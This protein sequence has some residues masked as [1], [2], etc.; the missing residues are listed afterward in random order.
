LTQ[1]KRQDNRIPG[2]ARMDVLEHRLKTYLEIETVLNR[3]FD[4]L[5]YCLDHCI[6]AGQSPGLPTPAC[7]K[8]RYYEKFDVDHPAFALLK[9]EREKRYGKPSEYHYTKRIS[10][11]EYHT[12]LG[13]RLKTHKS[14]VCLGFFCRKGI[15]FLRTRHGIL[16]YD[17]LGVYYALEWILTGDLTGKPLEDFKADCR[18]MLEKLTLSFKPTDGQ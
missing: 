2:D 17:Y 1:N 13:C 4:R 14:P 12:I 7:C 10:P 5:G 18:N 16:Q 11:C 15:D 9:S 8:D 6:A 3:F